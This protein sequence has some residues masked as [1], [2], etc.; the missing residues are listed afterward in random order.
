MRFYEMN[1]LRRYAFH[2]LLLGAYPVLALLAFNIEQTEAK[3]AIR[4]FI[5]TMIV[6]ILL[7]LLLRLLIRDWQKAALTCSMLVILFFTYGHIYEYLQQ[8]SVMVGRHRYIAP[9]WVIIFYPWIVV[10]D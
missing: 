5:V 3:T 6:V 7:L 10:G 1:A 8:V 4:A 9:L 2:P